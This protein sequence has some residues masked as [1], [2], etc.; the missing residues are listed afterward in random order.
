M[1]RVLHIEDD[2]DY[3]DVVQIHL[4]RR[5][6][7]AGNGGFGFDTAPTLKDAVDTACRGDYDCILCDYQLPDGTGLDV[8]R[9]VRRT[10]RRMPFIFLTGQGDE[11][12]ARDA[13]VSGASDYFTKDLGLAGFD[14]LYH[15]L[16][17]QLQLY[18]VQRERAEVRR[19]L[20]EKEHLAAQYFDVAGVLMLALD[21]RGIVTMVNTYGISLYGREDLPGVSFFS[22]PYC[23]PH[24]DELRNRFDAILADPRHGQQR[25]P[26]RFDL[27]SGKAPTLLWD[28]VPLYGSDGTLS[29]VLCS[30]TDVSAQA[31]MVHALERE[32]NTFMSVLESL[33]IGV[34]IINADYSIAYANPHLVSLFGP[35]EDK[36]CYAY[37]HGKDAPCEECPNETVFAGTSLTRSRS[38]ERIGKRFLLTEHP[39]YNDDGTVSKLELFYEVPES[40]E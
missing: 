18:E 33:R 4:R 31:R 8:L 28:M 34:Y 21:T 25:T 7:K 36:P 26:Y 38:Y 10:G 22:S 30:A 19:C 35:P 39:I 17:T 9:A 40:G 12:V 20:R 5:S 6:E 27:P 29:G 11:Q 14:R 23:A 15:A 16:L 24:G 3:A 32:R 2:G 13:F 37:L 1:Y